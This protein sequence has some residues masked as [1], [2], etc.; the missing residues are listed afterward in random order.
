MSDLELNPKPDNSVRNIL[1]GIFV[2]VLICGCVLLCCS[3]SFSILTSGTAT[4][5]EEEVPDAILDV[6]EY[7]YG[8]D[9][10]DYDD[11]EE[12]ISP[13]INK[14]LDESKPPGQK[15]NKPS[16]EESST[17]KPKSIKA[18]DAKLVKKNGKTYLILGGKSQLEVKNDSIK[19]KGDN[20]YLI[21]TS[22]KKIVIVGKQ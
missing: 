12:L 1:I 9:D 16:D 21:L 2:L 10:V 3:S 20:I 15:P 11:V 18:S 7:D 22:G 5:E 6:D 13:D 14:P 19:K 8:S 4:E 17:N